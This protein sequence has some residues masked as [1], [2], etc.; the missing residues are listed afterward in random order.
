MKTTSDIQFWHDHF[1]MKVQ[2]AVRD[3]QL[4]TGM[5]VNTDT[6]SGP[7]MLRIGS[8]PLIYYCDQASAIS[9]GYLLDVSNEEHLHLSARNK[10]V[11]P[12]R[13]IIEHLLAHAKP[14]FMVGELTN[15]SPIND[16]KV[17]NSRQ[18]VH[19]CK[20]DAR[21]SFNLD[22]L[23]ELIDLCRDIPI[24]TV[25]QTFQAYGMYST[26]RDRMS[27]AQAKKFEKNLAAYPLLAKAVR[28]EGVIMGCGELEALRWTR[29]E[30]KK[31]KEAEAA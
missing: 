7:K 9:F 13:H 6:N 12:K 30:P 27:A 8:T 28:L 16:M 26:N 22:K 14:P 21:F 4:S 31:D 19:F 11:L 20:A 29:H 3:P 10:D 18:L 24:A 25:M 15:R 17:S 23:A 2:D 5:T 1:A